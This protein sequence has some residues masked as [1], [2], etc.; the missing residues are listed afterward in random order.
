LTF[1][2]V[3]GGGAGVAIVKGGKAGDERQREMKTDVDIRDKGIDGRVLLEETLASGMIYFPG[4]VAF[5]KELRLQVKFRGEK[6]FKTLNI[7][8]N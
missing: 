8:L 5:A 4:E 1:G 3:S 7:K 6:R 2:V